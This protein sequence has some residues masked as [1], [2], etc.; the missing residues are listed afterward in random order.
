MEDSDDQAGKKK[1]PPQTPLGI[2]EKDSIFCQGLL[3]ITVFGSLQAAAAGFLNYVWD[4]HKPLAS[5]S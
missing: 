5:H 3:S 2:T 1:L 4:L